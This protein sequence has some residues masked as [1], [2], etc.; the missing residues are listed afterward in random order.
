MRKRLGMRLCLA[1][2][3]SLVLATAVAD[4][5]VPPGSSTL[6]AA[7]QLEQQGKKLRAEVD[8]EYKRL[9]ASGTLPRA[10]DITEI[11]QKYV[12]DGISFDDATAVL[13]AAGCQVGKTVSGKDV[14]AR[15]HLGGHFP[16]GAIFG[17]TLTPRS[18]GDFTLVGKVSASIIV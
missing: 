4:T 6:I 12:P 17:V 9:K 11:V 5:P 15:A 8:A 14:F 7:P 1:L 3:G 2:A 16:M 18:P 10:T 13:R